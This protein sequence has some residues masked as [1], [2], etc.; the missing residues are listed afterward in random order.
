MQNIINIALVIRGRYM[1][2]E[3]IL[4]ERLKQIKDYWVKTSIEGLDKNSDLIWSEC[5]TEYNLLQSIICDEEVKKA[6]STVVDELMKNIIH[7]ILVMFDG[8]DS[9][10]DKFNID[11]INADSKE[12]LKEE[13]S[14]NE[15]FLGYLLDSEEK[16][17]IIINYPSNLF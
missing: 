2:E 7:S 17:K 9:L 16:N 3:Q 12:S 15:E 13:S 6:Y 8:G 11:I 5:E 10:S 14:L 4:F 1:D